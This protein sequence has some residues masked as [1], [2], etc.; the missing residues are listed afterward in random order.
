MVNR[1]QFLQ[2]LGGAAAGAIASKGLLLE[3]PVLAW[4]PSTQ[5]AVV[6]ARIVCFSTPLHEDWL[7]VREQFV[8]E[9]TATMGVPPA[10]LVDELAAPPWSEELWPRH[11]VM[12]PG[13]HTPPASSWRRGGTVVDTGAVGRR[14]HGAA[15]RG[16]DLGAGPP[17]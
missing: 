4:D 6:G 13:C 1:R 14:R 10:Y 15:V 3:G 9:A 16:V 12:D 11:L 17:R 7:W 2:L 5:P 8:R